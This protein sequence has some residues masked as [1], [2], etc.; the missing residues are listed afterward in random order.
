M[1]FEKKIKDKPFSFY[2]NYNIGDLVNGSN[3]KSIIS[4][5]KSIPVSEFRLVYNHFGGGVHYFP[6]NYNRG[7]KPY[8]G[9]GGYIGFNRHNFSVDI[10]EDISDRAM[11]YGV[12]GAFG[13]RWMETRWSIGFE[14]RLGYN[15]TEILDEKKSTGLSEFCFI[16]VF[17]F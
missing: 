16:A 8:F 5:D 12:Y 9:F 3:K 7:F 6:L 2:A 4:N 10:V 14:H 1:K 15:Q 17:K 13:I 11:D